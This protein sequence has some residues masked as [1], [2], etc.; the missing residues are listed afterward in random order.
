MQID[1]KKCLKKVELKF[2]V[3]HFNWFENYNNIFSNSYIK[4]LI[5]IKKKYQKVIA[6]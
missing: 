5:K 1:V 6:L 4:K 2:S 3:E